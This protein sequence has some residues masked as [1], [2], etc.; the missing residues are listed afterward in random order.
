MRALQYFSIIWWVNRFVI[1]LPA[2]NARLK[3]KGT[4]N[5]M[6]IFLKKNEIN[7]ISIFN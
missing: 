6:M 4:N 5:D 3:F 7:P 1:S 2:T